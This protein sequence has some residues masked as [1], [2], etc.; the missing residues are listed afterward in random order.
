MDNLPAHLALHGAVI[1]VISF[2]AGLL[3]HKTIRL[4]GKNVA[5]WHLAHAGVSGRAVLLLALAG[6][7]QWVALPR[8]LL[9]LM[10]SLA[11]FFVWTSVAAMM[12]A[13]GAANGA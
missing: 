6:V 4:E 10:A 12:I 8:A 9:L 3:L 13:A 7:M 1:L 2:V 5:A 11:L